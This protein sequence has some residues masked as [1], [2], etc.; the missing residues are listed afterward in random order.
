VYT[1]YGAAILVGLGNGHMWPAFQNMVINLA[2]HNQRGTASS[3]VL[4][5]WDI[6]MGLGVLL[7]GL[8]AEFWGY[9]A[10]FWMMV[11]V[12]LVGLLLFVCYTRRKYA[13]TPLSQDL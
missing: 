13:A 2:N 8:V 5:T 9:N 12:H 11:A 4:T 6:G 3:T 10:A 7:G 1:Y